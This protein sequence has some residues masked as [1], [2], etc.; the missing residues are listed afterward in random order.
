MRPISQ[1]GQ[2]DGSTGRDNRQNLLPAAGQWTVF[3]S[4]RAMQVRPTALAV[5]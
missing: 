2:L 1:Y 5:P 3:S 4:S